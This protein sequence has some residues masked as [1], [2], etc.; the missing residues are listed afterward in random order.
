MRF[1]YAVAGM[2]VFVFIFSMAE[3]VATIP[4]GIS[5]NAY[6]LALAITF[7]GGMAGGDK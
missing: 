7:A 3:S 1:I 5:D 2:M 6:F 4:S